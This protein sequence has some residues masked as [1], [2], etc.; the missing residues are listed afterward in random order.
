MNHKRVIDVSLQLNKWDL[1]IQIASNGSKSKI[2]EKAKSECSKIAE[3]NKLQAAVLFN[4]VELHSEA[5]SL[6]RNFG[7]K[8]TK[9]QQKDLKT[10]KLIN[11]LAG[12]EMTT[13][14]NKMIHSVLS[15]ALETFE[16][17]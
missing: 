1:A 7:A 3:T 10:L 13:H 15:S 16:F 9:F 11:C 5:A 14:R 8:R 12:H 6:W 17:F 2:Q 4:Q